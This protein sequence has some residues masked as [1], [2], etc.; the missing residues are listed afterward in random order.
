MALSLCLLL[1]PLQAQDLYFT[2]LNGDCDGDNEVTLFDFGIVVNAFGSTPNDPNWDP[3]A[4]LDGDLEVTLFDYGIVVRNFGQIGAEP[5]DP[6]LPRQPML[7]TGYPVNGLVEIE[8][9]Q[10]APLVVRVEAV[11]EDVFEPVVFWTEV[12]AGQPFV[13]YLPDSGVWRLNIASEAYG[14]STALRLPKKIYHPG[15]GIQVLAVYPENGEAFADSTFDPAPIGLHVVPVDYD[16][17]G[18]IASDGTEFPLNKERELP[19]NLRCEWHLR[20]GRGAVV[21]VTGS[22]ILHSAL[23]Y[24]EELYPWETEQDVVV[25]CT[26]TDASSVPSRVDAPVVVPIRFRIVNRP[27][28]HISA[29]ADPIGGTP[30]ASAAGFP[31][32][33]RF[34]ASARL[35]NYWQLADPDVRWTT[36]WGTLTGRDVLVPVTADEK[37]R[38]FTFSATATFRGTPL[39]P[40]VPPQE[41]TDTRSASRILGFHRCYYDEEVNPARGATIEGIREPQN[42]FDN[43]PGH[44]GQVL[45]AY[46]FNE[47]DPNLTGQYVVYYAPAPFSNLSPTTL[48]LFDH[49]GEFG[50]VQYQEQYRGRIYIFQRPTVELYSDYTPLYRPLGHTAGGIDIVAIALIHEMAHRNWFIEDW[51]GFTSGHIGDHP[52]WKP[53]NSLWDL[54]RDGLGDKFENDDNNKLL[55]HCD[56]MLP[57]SIERWFLGTGAGI[58]GSIPDGELIAQLWGEWGN[59]GGAPPYVMGALDAEDWSVGGRQDY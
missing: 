33:V 51:G 6:A 55:Y 42:W 9:W 2:L 30:V 27:T 56:Y 58:Q 18:L 13:R 41:I 37:H 34:V 7:A 45:G 49:K 17:T 15:E 40:P 47:T 29:Q 22:G 32:V 20:S 10:G 21:P 36:P 11:R 59:P 57:Y 24:P 25:E 52:N 50:V 31:F 26:I 16:I 3:R 44:W 28:L 38:R 19:Q 4:D 54:D 8:E 23:Y 35:G 5:F 53:F 43:R 46:G 14:L 1:S 39:P 48:A 12:T